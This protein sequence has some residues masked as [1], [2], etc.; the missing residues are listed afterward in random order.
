M[1]TLPGLGCCLW[2]IL[3]Y[4][5][6]AIYQ[7]LSKE[8]FIPSTNTQRMQKTL[9]TIRAQGSTIV[10][11]LKDDRYLNSK[12][13]RSAYSSLIMIIHCF[14]DKQWKKPD[15][16]MWYPNSLSLKAFLNLSIDKYC[17]LLAALYG[18]ATWYINASFTRNNK[19]LS[20]GYQ[21]YQSQ[22]LILIYCCGVLWNILF[23]LS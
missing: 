15:Y 22:F 23:I 18:I 7:K 10:P 8:V 12:T 3:W 14:N 16:T 4:Y 2:K 20:R 6:Y 1:A 21:D 19:I 17:P 13:Y 5:G 9:A 11:M